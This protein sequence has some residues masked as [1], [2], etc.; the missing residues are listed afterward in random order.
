MF[1]K[2]DYEAW[3]NP[4]IA[5]GYSST[6]SNSLVDREEAYQKVGHSVFGVKN[7]VSSLNF[8]QIS[9]IFF[10]LSFPL[11]LQYSLYSQIK[12][13]I[14]AVKE[15]LNSHDKINTSNYEAFDYFNANSYTFLPDKPT[16]SF[17]SQ[18][19]ILIVAKKILHI[20]ETRYIQ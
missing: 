8:T 7:F 13:T 4:C 20:P 16:V 18:D 1:S 10:S 17:H 15:D 3:T 6:G 19:F 12:L 14:G 11:S 9:Q 5:D 2:Q